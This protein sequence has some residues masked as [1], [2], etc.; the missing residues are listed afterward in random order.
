MPVAVAIG[1]ARTGCGSDLLGVGWRPFPS[2]TIPQGG[3]LM[4]NE[5]AKN[6]REQ[7]RRQEHEERREGVYRSERSL[8]MPVAA[9]HQP[10]R[11]PVQD[12]AGAR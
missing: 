2:T 3:A 5:R 10:R 4:A 7:E 11:L 12:A 6:T 9:R 8:T 1:R